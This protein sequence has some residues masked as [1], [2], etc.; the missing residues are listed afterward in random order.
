MGAC[1]GSGYC[2]RKAPC[3]EAWRYYPEMSIQ[4]FGSEDSPGCP[5]LR[6]RDGRHW[7]GLVEDA[8]GEEKWRLQQS[9][10]IGAGCCSSLNSTRLE[11]L[12]KNSAAHS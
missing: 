8:Q 11:I 3:W 5:A 12:R 1:V 7:C 6:E 4:N 2:C 10:S 9:L